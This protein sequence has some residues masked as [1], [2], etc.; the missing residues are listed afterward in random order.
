MSHITDT[1]IKKRVERLSQDRNYINELIADMFDA[2][3]HDYPIMID[4]VH[5]LRQVILETTYLQ[6]IAIAQL[7]DECE[8][9]P[10][11]HGYANA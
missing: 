2:E 11:A 6:D 9:V 8:Y 1:Q 5:R 3:G 4:D 10:G 7:H